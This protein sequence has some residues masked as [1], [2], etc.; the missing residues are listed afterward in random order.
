LPKCLEGEVR[1]LVGLC[2]DLSLGPVTGVDLALEKDVD[3]TVRAVLH[4]W[5]KEVCQ[6]EADETSSGPYVTALSAEI[7][8]LFD[9]SNVQLKNLRERNLTSG[10][11]M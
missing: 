1:L 8:F 2:V 7:G 3:L 5:Y 9:V 4:L 11:S 10:L 6:D